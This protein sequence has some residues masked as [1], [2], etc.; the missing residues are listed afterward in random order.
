MNWPYPR[1]VAHRGGGKLAPENTLS[2]IDTGARYGHTMVEF[3]ANLS[4]G[5]QIF[6]LHDDTL[7]WTSNSWGVVG[8]RTLEALM[9]VDAGGWFSSEYKGEKLP[10]LAE[11]AQRCCQHVMM[12]NIEIKPTSGTGRETGRT[13]SLAAHCLWQGMTSPLLS[14]FDGGSAGG[15]SRCFR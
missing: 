8:E 3:D 2:A 13:V 10:L 9:N 14:S 5:G 12:A 6:L 11:A 7:E 4:K 1:I 15:C